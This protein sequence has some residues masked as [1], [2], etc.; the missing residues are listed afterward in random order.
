MHAC[1][2]TA[3]HGFL[4]LPCQKLPYIPEIKIARKVKKVPTYLP[5]ST[6]RLSIGFPKEAKK[7][8]ESSLQVI[9]EGMN[10][11]MNDP[12]HTVSLA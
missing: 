4:V 6:A 12:P 10:E 3:S 8:V 5:V 7:V 2:G 11:W 1:I 9:M